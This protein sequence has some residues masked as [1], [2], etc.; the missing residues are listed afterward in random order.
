MGSSQSNSC[1]QG[2]GW[3]SQLGGEPSV[4]EHETARSEFCGR[5][6]KAAAMAVD[7]KISSRHMKGPQLA[8]EGLLSNSIGCYYRRRL[9][10]SLKNTQTVFSQQW[11]RHARRGTRKYEREKC[12]SPFSKE[13]LVEDCLI[14][15][16]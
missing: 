2:E 1:T 5:R 3:G 7:G 12:G 9:N 10:W 14:G 11:E 13:F 4:G 16:D 6:V 15:R 8:E